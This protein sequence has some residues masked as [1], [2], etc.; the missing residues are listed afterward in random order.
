MTTPRFTFGKNWTDYVQKHMTP[1]AVSAAMQA[2]LELVHLPSLDGM[3]VLDIGCG[4]GIH[5]LAAYQSGATEVVSFDY[6]IDSVNIS[7]TLHSEAGS[8]L[9]WTVQ[10]GSVL[11]SD[12]M[13]QLGQFDLV[14]AWGVLHHTGDMMSALKN[15]VKRVAPNGMFALA[16]YSYTAYQNNTVFGQPTPEEW[17][18]I[19]QSYV[20]GNNWVKRRLVWEY[21]WRR[22][23]ARAGGNPFKF[24]SCS[25]DFFSRWMDYK[26]NSRG[27]NFFTDIK[28]W[29]GGWPMEFMSEKD[30]LSFAKE[31]GLEFLTMQTGRGNTEY[32]FRP[33]GC[34]NHWDSLLSQRSKNLLSAPFEQVSKYVWRADVPQ[35]IPFDTPKS[36]YCS[37]LRLT[38]DGHAWGFAHCHK[39]SME[40]FGMGRYRHEEGQLLFTS[41][42]NSDPNTNGRKYEWYL[43]K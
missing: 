10:Q 36:P 26:K 13:Q 38:E 40:L 6:D 8:P 33:Q 29:V 9:N 12:F 39:P 14:Y 19:K 18:T 41:S 28:D 7:K 3:R 34:R 11:D 27:M 22:Y 24:I 25:V 21:V 4:S 23:F 37:P 2:L 16:L 31:V 20:A 35:S 1:D 5:S 43:D 15:A 32:L 30:C 17:L 42:D